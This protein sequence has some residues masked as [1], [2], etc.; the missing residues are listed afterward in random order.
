MPVLPLVAA[1]SAS[2]FALDVEARLDLSAHPVPA[3]APTV[4]VHAPPDLPPQGATV[5]LYLH[6]WEGCARAIVASGAVPCLDGGAPT[7]GWGLGARHDEAGTRS[8]LVVPQL[9]WRARTGNPGRFREP[10]FA[11]A[12]LAELTEEVLAP[13]LGLDRVD[14]LVVVA[15]SGGYLTA[16]ELLDALP[17]R[18]VVLLDALYGGADRVASWVAAGEERRAVSLYTGHPGTTGQ[19]QGLAR[20]VA[21][22]LGPQRVAVDPPAAGAALAGHRVVVG[23]TRWHHGAVPEKH[24]AEIL[25]GLVPR[26]EVAG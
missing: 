26:R 13:R 11:A 18:G 2:A 5:V 24:L 20:R 6:G 4:V 1:V 22:A 15:H 23:S 14:D 8:V 10:G 17:V 21:L 19:S 3:G 7:A 16:L 12:W 25:A 9:A